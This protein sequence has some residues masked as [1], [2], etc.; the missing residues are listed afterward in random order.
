MSIAGSPYLMPAMRK[1]PRPKVT[2]S[3]MIQTFS[4]RPDLPLLIAATKAHIETAHGVGLELLTDLLPI[5]NA[6]LER[7]TERKGPVQG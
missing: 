4:K 1:A 5:L 3:E 6:A 7:Q 2:A